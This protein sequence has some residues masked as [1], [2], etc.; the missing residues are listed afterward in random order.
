MVFLASTA[1]MATG[2]R[3]R[4]RSW[5][6][7]VTG[8]PCV[9]FAVRG[10]RQKLQGP[11]H[12]SHERGKVPAVVAVTAVTAGTAVVAD[13]AA[14]AFVDGTEIGPP[15]GDRWCRVVAF[16]TPAASAPASA[17][18]VS[19]VAGGTRGHTFIILS[20]SDLLSWT[21]ILSPP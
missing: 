12:V 13:S 11:T 1:L 8:T 14:T 20:R 16:R 10:A 19:R 18:G 5:S 9:R 4:T 2:H 6:S 21:Y 3:R 15:G 17:A 7:P